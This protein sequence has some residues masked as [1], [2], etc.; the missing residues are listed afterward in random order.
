LK[1]TSVKEQHQQEVDHELE[2]LG[3]YKDPDE[4]WIKIKS[5]LENIADKICGKLSPKKRKQWI[6]TEILQ[7]MD[8]GRKY[9]DSSNAE[10]RRKYKQLKREIQR[11]CRKAKAEFYN[12]QCSEVEQLEKEHSPRMYKKGKGND[13]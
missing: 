12:Q 1:D 13:E 5:S 7:N 9:K 11:E 8:E 3:D 6:I 4:L 2:D 10:G